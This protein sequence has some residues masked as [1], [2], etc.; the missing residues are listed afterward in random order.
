M[1]RGALGITA[2]KDRIAVEAAPSTRRRGGWRAKG[3]GWIGPKMEAKIFL[4]HAREDKPEIRKLYADLTAL[5]L[6]PWLDEKLI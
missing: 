4:A 1:G 6:D 5:G 2:D 3:K